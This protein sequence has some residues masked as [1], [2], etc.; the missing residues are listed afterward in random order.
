MRL[1]LLYIC[2]KDCASFLN[3]C[4]WRGK[5][6]CEYRCVALHQAD[7]CVAAVSL[8]QSYGLVPVNC[9]YLCTGGSRS[10]H[11]LSMSWIIIISHK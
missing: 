8:F 2:F 4:V 3:V 9:N 10:M 11:A 1:T 7:L 5:I 6:Q